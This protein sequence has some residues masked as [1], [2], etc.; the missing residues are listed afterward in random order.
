MFL[1]V[2]FG[3]GY[4]WN[5]P[6]ITINTGDIVRYGYNYILPGY[7]ESNYLAENL[8]KVLYF[9]LSFALPSLRV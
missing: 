5:T 7:L 8:K 6:V 1:F 9:D 4:A 3:L 2:D